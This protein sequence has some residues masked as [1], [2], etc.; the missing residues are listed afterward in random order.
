MR[1][2]FIVYDFLQEFHIFL[3]QFTFFGTFDD[4][5]DVSSRWFPFVRN[6]RIFQLD[7]IQWQ[8]GHLVQTAFNY[9]TVWRMHLLDQRNI[10]I[11]VNTFLAAGTN[12][13]WQDLIN[14]SANFHFSVIKMLYQ[15]V[16]WCHVR[17]VELPNRSPYIVII[18]FDNCWWRTIPNGW[19]VVRMIEINSMTLRQWNTQWKCSNGLSIMRIYLPSMLQCS[20]WWPKDFAIECDLSTNCCRTQNTWM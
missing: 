19:L 9:F 17:Q 11:D 4:R 13:N 6:A 8:V 7:F 3:R 14:D 12:K 1:I 10:L 20:F 2:A 5:V 15:P 18:I 16:Q